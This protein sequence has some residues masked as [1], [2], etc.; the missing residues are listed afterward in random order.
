MFLIVVCAAISSDLLSKHYVFKWLLNDPSLRSQID[1]GPGAPLSADAARAALGLYQREVPLGVKLTLSVNPG[2]VFGLHVPRP[3]VVVASVLT[4]VLVGYFFAT[5]ERSARLVHVG[6]ALILGGALGNLYDRLF[7]VVSVEGFEP[8]AYHVRDFI[9]CSALHYPW[10]FNV[11]DAWLVVG[12]ALLMLN[13]LLAAREQSRREKTAR[14][15][16]Q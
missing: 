8:I 12:V 11:A 10:V 16:E 6:L 5:S 14:Q 4:A 1:V 2:V 7:S 13:W 3:A 15:G 9:D